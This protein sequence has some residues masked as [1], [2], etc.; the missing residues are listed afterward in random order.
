MQGRCSILG[1][2][3]D[4][5]G[6]PI[7]LIRPDIQVTLA[8]SQG[9]K[10]AFL[11]EVVRELG[12]QSEVWGDSGW[13]QWLGSRRFDVVAMRAVDGD[14]GCG[15]GSSRSGA[16]GRLLVLGTE[17]TAGYPELEAFGG[18]WCA[19][20]A[21][22]T[23]S[24]SLRGDDPQ[25]PHG[26]VRLFVPLLFHVEHNWDRSTWHIQS[27][28]RCARVRPAISEAIAARTPPS[29]T[30]DPAH[31]KVIAVVNQK[32]GVGKTTTAINLAAALALGRSPNPADRLRPAGQHHRRP[33]FRRDDEHRPATSTTLLMG[34]ATAGEAISPTEVP[35]SS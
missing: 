15:G 2:V 18:W 16:T 23:V 4:F 32:G 12:L 5:R 17:T 24:C 19:S 33:G 20:R 8:E 22:R 3:R 28:L 21:P 1:R 27:S 34:N 11:R 35:I 30:P 13:R 29:K 25:A 10:A 31:S 9:K 7:Q 6:V 26:V 14:G